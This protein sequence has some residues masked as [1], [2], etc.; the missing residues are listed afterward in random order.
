MKALIAFFLLVKVIAVEVA[1]LAAFLG[2]LVVVVFWEWN[3]LAPF[4]RK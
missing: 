2:I 1:S 3:H 4:L